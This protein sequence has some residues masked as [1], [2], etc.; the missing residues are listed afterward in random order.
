M[1]AR[2]RRRSRSR[3]S[4]RCQPGRAC[5]CSFAVAGLSATIPDDVIART[6]TLEFA[7]G[8][9][10]K[11]VVIEVVGDDAV[12]GPEAFRLVLS[13]ARPRTGGRC[14]RRQ[15]ARDHRRRRRR[16]AADSDADTYPDS[17]P[18]PTP[19]PTPT[20]TPPTPNPTPNPTPTPTP[21]PTPPADHA[22]TV[23]AGSRTG[24]PEGAAVGLD[25]T[26]ND[27][28]AGD[29]LTMRWTYQAGSDVDSGAT[30]TFERA[31]RVDTSIVC[32]DDGT[33]TASLTVTDAAGHAASDDVTVVVANADPGVHISA[34]SDSRPS[35]SARWWP[36]RPTLPIRAARTPPP[37]ASTGARDD[38]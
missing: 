25:A 18:N 9:G 29:T 10:P 23:D 33:Y 35:G 38:G 36:C 2:R 4:R 30:C 20:P 8:D 28:D 31:S 13:G 11:E 1:P 3:S 7:S 19:D 12:E 34:P 15:P 22:P 24:G 6:G 16:G 27:A 17:D 26:A 32:T 14:S 21:T 5:R 37:A